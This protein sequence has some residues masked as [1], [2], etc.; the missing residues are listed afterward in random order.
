MLNSCGEQYS[1]QQIQREVQ[2]SCESPRS[3]ESSSSLNVRN[4]LRKSYSA[5]NTI[6]TANAC[7]DLLRAWPITGCVL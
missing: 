1:V 3:S 5:I 7:A 4:H 2:R 6:E